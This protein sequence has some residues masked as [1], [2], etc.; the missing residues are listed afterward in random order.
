ML[1][2]H[3]PPSLTLLASPASPDSPLVTYLRDPG[4]TL[5]AVLSHVAQWG[6]VWG[7]VAG[8]ALV[9][10]ASGLGAVR[11]WWRRRC[12]RVLNADARIVSVLPPPTADPAG[13]EAL[14][15]NLLGLL[16][17]AWRRRLTGQ[18]HLAWEYVFDRETI[19]IRLW[20]PGVVPPGMVERAIEAAWPGAHT[21]TAPAP[22]PALLA[23][24]HAETAGG[25]LRLARPEALPIRTD[26]PAD[27]IRA[28]L[29]APVSTGEQAVVQ[30]LARPVTGRRIAKARR[31]ARR[32]RAGHPVRPV[33]RLLDVLTPGY[34]PPRSR[35]AAPVLDRQTALE[36]S[37][38]DKVIVAKQRGAPY[39]TRIRY[40]ITAT[41]PDEASS[42]HRAAVRE[43]LRGRGQAIAS[44]FAAFTEHNYYR[45]TKLRRPEPRISERRL[46]PGDLLSIPELASVA[47]LPWDEAIPGLQRAGARAV[48]P[49][50][51]IATTGP[52]V[53]PI[54]LTDTGHPRPVGLR[55][56]DARHHLHILGATGSGKSELMARMILADAEAGRG[57]VAI[58]PKG[59][60][61]TD[62]LMRLPQELGH[63]VIL[64]DADSKARPPIL[65]P[66]EGDDVARTVDNLVSIFSRVY[67]SS[68][69]PRTDDILRAGLL[70][71][72]AQGGIPVLTDLPKLLAVPS[73]RQRAVDQI[74]D[75][76]LQ[77][78]WSWYDA[79]SGPARAQVTAPLMNKLRG[80]L[81]RPFV[82]AALAGGTSTVDMD[83]VLDGGI[84]LVRIAKDA[85]GTETAHLM[86]SIVVARTWQATTR[87]AHISQGQR[88]DAGLY[89]DEAHNFLNLPYA[90]ED[91]LAEARG[92][93][94]S[95]T[96]A[97]QYLR[98]LPKVLEEGIS[99]NARTKIFFNASPEDASHLA[100]HT[101]PRVTA[102]DLSNLDA[103]HAVVRPV[104]HGA[105]A[106]AFTAVT[107]PLP[108]PVP[109]RA[110]Q[111]RATARR[112][113]RP[114]P[115]STR[116]TTGEQAADP[117]RPT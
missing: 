76:I 30:V 14:W 53:R 92:Y 61:I 112:N 11:W 103:F 31:A 25:E 19:R 51:G 48:P 81:L 100:R 47:H 86:G 44:A 27:P 16:R 9:L 108:P 107:E 59:D 38:E 114:Q 99:T 75:D 23:R 28:L 71:L 113:A 3:L 56:P 96:L 8:P 91:M 88:P 84:C 109:G 18:P 40:A 17:P 2:G 54:G 111:I 41:V 21:R 66:L 82:R 104:L 101:E 62:V 102:H 46:G 57:L 36:A 115:V 97:H 80:F 78:F 49:P 37:A 43:R 89:L 90:L 98:Q 50:P 35:R 55:V 74:D 70:T 58:D 12:R 10:A 42:E 26:F 60:L 22:P 32:A 7:P 87:R 110:K 5:R 6:I 45:R 63:K 1:L 73:F 69:G 95:M 13:A 117:R 34:R 39:E 83:A 67:A 85:L 24:P 65:N 15:A 33:S 79:L 52:A 77:G 93:R 105:E 72:R 106:P 4:G 68:W 29:G 94:L 64:F 116:K 20:V